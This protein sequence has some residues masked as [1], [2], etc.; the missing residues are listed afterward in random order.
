M[1]T[2]RKTAKSALKKSH[3]DYF[4]A[5]TAKKVFKAAKTMNTARK[6][7]EKEKKRKASAKKKAMKL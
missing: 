5:K 6:V 7:L 1:A 4:S 3:S 2:K